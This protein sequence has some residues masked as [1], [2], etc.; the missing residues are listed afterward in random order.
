MR[1][2]IRKH[3]FNENYFEIID[4]EEK[5]YWLGFIA[6]DGCISKASE[7]NSYRLSINISDIDKS[8][9]EL[10]QK[11][12]D[13]SDVEIKTYKNISGYSSKDGTLTSRI[14]LNSYKMCTDLMKYN[15]HERKSYDIRFP[16]I[17]DD[18][19]PHF[20]RGYF[21]GDGCYCVYYSKDINKNRVSFELVGASYEFMLDV[22]KYLKINGIQTNI[23]QRKSN[24]SYR[25]MTCSKIQI[26]K[27]IDFLYH[28][29]SICLDR[30][31]KK[32]NEIK[33]IAV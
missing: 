20:I 10:F 7:Y 24:N 9:L 17:R 4:N 21:D 26:L 6:A 19:K 14:V 31:L 23:Y 5:A 25:L 30:K 33:S 12:I 27:L 11:C 16:K 29:N 1:K 18:L 2:G 28:D 13:A 22:Q 8:H 15:I 3:Y 32:I